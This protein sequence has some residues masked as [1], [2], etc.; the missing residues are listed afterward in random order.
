MSEATNLQNNIALG[1]RRK[2]R[3]TIDGDKERFIEL[4]TGDVG[5]ISRYAK[6]IPEINKWSEVV[7][8]LNFNTDSDESCIEFNTKF[9]EADNY[10]RQIINEL[11]DYDVCGVC[12]GDNGSMFDITNGKFN[13]EVIVEQ[14]FSLYDKT[15]SDE[16]KRLQKRMRSHTDKYMP[17]DRKK[18]S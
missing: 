4:N 17:Q 16:T 6:A 1:I 18:K 14:L 8:S 2:E 12:V 7:D 3:F 13:F 9:K 5:I 10:M 15:I 11:F